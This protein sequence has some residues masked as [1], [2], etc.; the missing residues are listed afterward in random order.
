MRPEE[1]G[2]R[3]FPAA[4]APSDPAEEVS[5]SLLLFTDHL[6][7]H[8]GWWPAHLLLMIWTKWQTVQRLKNS[9]FST[10]TQL[11]TYS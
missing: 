11:K 2:M 6:N 8:T 9:Q 5:R 1:G 3:Q 7:Y 4:E 10:V